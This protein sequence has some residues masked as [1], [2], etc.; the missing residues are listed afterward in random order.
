M[1]ESL[2]SHD[3]SR[4]LSLIVASPKPERASWL[5]EKA[6]E[7][8]VTRIAWLQCSRSARRFSDSV[9]ARHGRIAIAALEQC[10]GATLPVVSGPHEWSEL[11]G[12]L[13]V[14]DRWWTLDTAG[15]PGGVAESDVAFAGARALGLV[16]GPEGGWSDAERAELEALGGAFWSLGERT[17]RVETAAVVGAGLLLASR[18]LLP[19][20]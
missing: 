12:L 1:G 16:I 3:S 2:P 4:E 14:L 15:A 17:L 13:G 20:G 19:P 11:G 9:L 8:G 7:L 10:G 5:V 6:T 18:G